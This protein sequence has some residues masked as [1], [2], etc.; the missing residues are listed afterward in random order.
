MFAFFSHGVPKEKVGN[1]FST[2]QLDKLV[3]VLSK[4]HFKQK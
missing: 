3:D 4:A 1:C 2:Y